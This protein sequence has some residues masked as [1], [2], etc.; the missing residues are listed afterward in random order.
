MGLL[1]A[2]VRG[3]QVG[4]VSKGARPKPAAEPRARRRQVLPSERTPHYGIVADPVSCKNQEFYPSKSPLI[5]RGFLGA[6]YRGR[7]VHDHGLRIEGREP[8]ALACFFGR[9][10]LFPMPLASFQ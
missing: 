2:G 10:V 6:E 9:S 4:P 8:V 1:D 3:C 5:E 7:I